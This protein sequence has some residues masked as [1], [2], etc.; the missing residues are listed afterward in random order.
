MSFS[1]ALVCF[2][3]LFVGGIQILVDRGEVIARSLI[4]LVSHVPLVHLHGKFLDIIDSQVGDG[5]LSLSLGQL[6]QTSDSN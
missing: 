1:I 5:L 3:L 2:L 4:P 6:G